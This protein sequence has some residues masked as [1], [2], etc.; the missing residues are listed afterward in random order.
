[1]PA[2]I[3]LLVKKAWFEEKDYRK[4]VT[5]DIN[6]RF[7]LYKKWDVIRRIFYFL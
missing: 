6:I 2:L 5:T 7:F 4:K 1:M 3:F